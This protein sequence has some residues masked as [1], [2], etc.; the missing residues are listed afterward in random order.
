MTVLVAVVTYNSERLLA[1]LIDGLRVG[2]DG[3]K[4]HLTVADN[5]SKDDSVA[6]VRRLA[7]EATVV[8]MGRNAGY[9]AGINAA[10]A[11]SPAHDAILVL[12]P[13]VRLTPG[14]ITILLDALTEPGTG[15]AV[16]N[17]VDGDGELI[18]TM[19]RDPSVLRTLGDAFLG[20]RRAGRFG[21]L[22]EVVAD[23]RL[24]AQ[25]RFA[26]WA[27]GSTMLVSAECW[28][29]CGPWD[30]SFFLYSEET[31]FALRA[32]DAGLRT[33][34]VPSAKATHLE[35]D[36]RVSPGLWSLLTLNKVRLHR[37]RHGRA[38][39]GA[40][41][42]A[43]LLRESSRAVLGKKPSR[44]ATRDLLTPSRMRETP[45]PASVIRWS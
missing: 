1:D 38:R 9:A 15:I 29:R 26:D 32:R 6:T 41:W 18:Y 22:G 39:A 28:E 19:R 4:W 45:G 12:N 20:A 37:K 31:D 3:V 11:A 23:E 7:P 2:L 21:P 27:E 36:S 8:E 34:Y 42:A 40:L 44:A 17:I 33:R 35:G 16:P 43:L 25:E 24:Y 10:V 13:D 5:D 14:C 30:E